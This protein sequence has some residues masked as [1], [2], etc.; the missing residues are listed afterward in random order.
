MKMSKMKLEFMAGIGQRA[1]GR[2]ILPEESQ[3]VLD[4]WLA[5][6]C[7]YYG[8]A[9][10]ARIQGGWIAPSGELVTEPGIVATILTVE[11]DI[12]SL[13]FAAENFAESL[14]RALGQHSVF[15]C[16]TPIQAYT[17]GA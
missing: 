8:G 9:S 10:I 16:V 3:P 4:R 1:D 13:M 7:H 15:V 17:V 6:L 5:E 14:R 11:D 12:P 2:T